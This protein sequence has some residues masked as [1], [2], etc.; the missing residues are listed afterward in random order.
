YANRYKCPQVFVFDSVHLVIVQFRAA[1]RDLIRNENCIVDCC[2][3]P[4]EPVYF[5]QCTIQYALYRLAWRGWMRL[6]AT[7]LDRNDTRQSLDVALNGIPRTYEWFS[8]RPVWE[9]TRG[10]F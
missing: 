6:S 5:E 10:Q 7:L 9:V 1:S 2:V 4:R 8:G 3:I